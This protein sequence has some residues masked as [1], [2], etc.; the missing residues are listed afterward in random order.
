M[1]HNYYD[2][3]INIV[4]F[5]FR[6]QGIK[7]Q[8]QT[9]TKTT[10][11]PLVF[12]KL[13]KIEVKLSVDSTALFDDP[14][15]FSLYRQYLPMLHFADLCWASTVLFPLNSTQ[16]ILLHKS[17]KEVEHWLS[18]LTQLVS[19]KYSWP[20]HMNIGHTEAQSQHEAPAR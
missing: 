9:K 14:L 6:L 13:Y 15:D 10:K 16:N 7:Y 5:F 8:N 17:W 12:L 11:L 20:K 18:Y 3:Y 19:D 2:Y 4:I 1:F